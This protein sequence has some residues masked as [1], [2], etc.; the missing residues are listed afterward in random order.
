MGN[1]TVLR[2]TWHSSERENDARVSMD[3]WWIRS[4]YL[5]VVLFDDLLQ[6][7]RVSIHQSL[8]LLSDERVEDGST[9]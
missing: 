5:F 1:K 8:V 4:F 9:A 2:K 7:F 6:G 3:I